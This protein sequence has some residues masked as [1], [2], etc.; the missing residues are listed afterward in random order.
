MLRFTAVGLVV[1]LAEGWLISLVSGNIFIV[2]F[3]GALG[4]LVGLIL[5]V[6]HRNDR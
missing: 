6:I 1:G 2:I 5:G 3:G 4:T